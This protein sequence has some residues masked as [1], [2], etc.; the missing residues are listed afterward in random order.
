M[1]SAVHRIAAWPLSLS[2]LMG[3]IF[4]GTGGM[5]CL[6]ND[7]YVKIETMYQACCREKAETCTFE[8]SFT[9]HAHHN[10]QTD[11]T[12]FLLENLGWSRRLSKIKTVETDCSSPQFVLASGILAAYANFA[13]ERYISELPV[14]C[15][16]SPVFLSTIRLIC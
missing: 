12:D 8:G 5:L 13:D 7:G 11:C 15:H 6:C 10:C 3:I 2:F 16:S 4:S 14:N 1:K 9:H